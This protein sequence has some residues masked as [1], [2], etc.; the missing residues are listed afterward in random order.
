MPTDFRRDDDQDGDARRCGELS[1]A[2]SSAVVHLLA[3]TVGRGPTKA[4]TTISD[5][6]IVVLLQ[7]SMT[8]GERSLVNAGRHDEVLRI[9][10]AYQATM[11][12][13]LVGAVEGLTDRAVVAFMS[14][15]HCEPDA[16]AEIFVM[17]RPVLSA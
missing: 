13:D 14:A 15:N 4:R 6:L 1:A 10:R 2:I 3:Q 8:S 17:D 16:A 12:P 5:E 11:E 9:R 7:D